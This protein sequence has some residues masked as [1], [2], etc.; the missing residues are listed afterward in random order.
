MSLY[1]T[2]R[3]NLFLQ[4]WTN[5]MLGRLLM[6]QNTIGN[7]KWEGEGDLACP[8]VYF[9]IFL[10]DAR[11]NVNE[12]KLLETTSRS[13]GACELD[14]HEYIDGVWEGRQ[15]HLDRIDEWTFGVYYTLKVC[16]N[17]IHSVNYTSTHTS[18]NTHGRTCF[19][20][21]TNFAH[22]ASHGR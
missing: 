7:P 3:Q 13:L 20:G 15:T 17:L 11:E 2:R 1:Q 18:R 5:L 4:L 9:Q 10:S 19:V 21:S 16:L 6:G 22:D 14:S 8:K 12:T